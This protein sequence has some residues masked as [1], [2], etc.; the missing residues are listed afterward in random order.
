MAS[1]SVIPVESGAAPSGGRL[2]RL[3]LQ[4]NEADS[5]VLSADK[6]A[7]VLGLGAPG[8]LR[9]IDE[10]QSSGSYAL[11]C[12]GRSCDGQVIDLLVGPQ[13]LALTVLSTRWSLPAA[14]APLKAAQPPLARAQYLPDATIVVSRVRI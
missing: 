10:K 1:A 13:P 7:Q 11:A 6:D 14:A 3:R 12:T 9:R 2:V 8:Q 4:L 5:V